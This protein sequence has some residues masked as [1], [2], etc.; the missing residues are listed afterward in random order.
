MKS[1]LAKSLVLFA[2]LTCL[3]ARHQDTGRKVPWPCM[4]ASAIPSLDVLTWFFYI[5]FS[6]DIHFVYVLLHFSMFV[7]VLFFSFMLKI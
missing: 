5:F 1:H 2:F 6:Q 7:M 3:P 4:V